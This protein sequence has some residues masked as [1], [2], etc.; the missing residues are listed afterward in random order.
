[1]S[2]SLYHYTD[3]N[4]LLGILSSKSLWL[5]HIGYLNDSSEYSHAKVLLRGTLEEMAKDSDPEIV[6][7]AKHLSFWPEPKGEIPALGAS[8]FVASLSMQKDDLSQWRAYSTVGA[9]YC[10][11]FD[12]EALNALVRNAG[13]KL[14]QVDYDEASVRSRIRRIYPDSIA[15]LEAEGK[16]HRN[17]QGG[18]SGKYDGKIVNERV[19]EEMGPWIKNSKFSSEQE[20][21]IVARG[22]EAT[23]EGKIHYRVGRSF[24]IPYLKLRLDPMTS[25]ILA[26]WV[27]PSAHPVHSV[28]SIR[29]LLSSSGWGS[30][31]ES[32]RPA[33][34]QI[35]LLKS[36]VPYRDW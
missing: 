25:P 7:L 17:V 16:L 30:A 14:E 19:L 4:G 15:A 36:E 3:G 26:I 8:R 33:P 5:T 35:L 9:R 10:I 22:S 24:L 23:F 29:M 21:R 32:T 27:G 18:F 12:K 6:K 31:S 1:M 20:W 13:L 28:E 11:E 34:A 2:Q